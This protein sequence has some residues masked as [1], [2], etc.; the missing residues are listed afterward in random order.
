MQTLDN[1]GAAFSLAIHDIDV[2]GAGT[3]LVYEQSGHVKEVGIELYQELLRE[4][5]EAAKSGEGV[6]V[7][8]GSWTPQIAIGMPVMIPEAYV[9]D[10]SVRMSLYRRIATLSD[11]GEIDAF[12][13]EMRYRF[14]AMPVAVDRN[15]GLGVT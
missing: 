6:D 8:E 13:A 10:L 5:V 15:R 9:P 12:A 14:G 1:P 4:A 11:E 3:L 7:A 2:R